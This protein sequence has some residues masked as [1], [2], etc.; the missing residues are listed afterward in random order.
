MWKSTT[1]GM[2]TWPAIHG[3]SIMN[4][5]T[6]VKMENYL[7]TNLIDNNYY[8]LLGYDI[9][10]TNEFEPILLEINTGPA[11]ENYTNLDKPIKTSLFIDTLNLI[12]IIPFSKNNIYNIINHYQTDFKINHSVENAFCELTRPRGGYEYIFPLKSNIDI[13]KKY[14]KK[15]LEINE[16]FWKKI[17]KD[18]NI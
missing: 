15:K 11:L 14:F 10:V 18:L 17:S 9:I 3:I 6:Q 5:L 7:I 8:N 1:T 2:P 12:G 16:L 4:S 13:Y